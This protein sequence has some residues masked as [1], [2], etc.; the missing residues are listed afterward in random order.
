MGVWRAIESGMVTM[1]EVKSGIVTLAD[2][3]RITAYLD[4]KADFEYN[5]QETLKDKKRG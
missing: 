5:V 3:Q 4:L 2:I 1:S